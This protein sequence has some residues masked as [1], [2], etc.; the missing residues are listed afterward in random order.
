MLVTG[1]KK[2]TAMRKAGGVDL[3]EASYP[4][5]AAVRSQGS[6]SVPEQRLPARNRALQARLTSSLC[7][8]PT[9]GRRGRDEQ[10]DGP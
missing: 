1:F 2:L 5:T 6:V 10:G 8:L 7:V 3:L 4:P 9:G